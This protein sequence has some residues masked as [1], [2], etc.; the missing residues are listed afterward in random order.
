MYSELSWR[1]Q[2]SLPTRCSKVCRTLSQR[3]RKVGHCELATAG[4]AHLS[5]SA[6]DANQSGESTKLTDRSFRDIQRSHRS[7]VP[8]HFLAPAHNHSRADRR[9]KI[10]R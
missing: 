4:V 9:T 1:A 7:T 2:C 5:R 10:S 6:H 3:L 8:E